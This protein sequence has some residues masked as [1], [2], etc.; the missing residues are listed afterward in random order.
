MPKQQTKKRLR[1][2][3][4]EAADGKQADQSEMN[5]AMMSKMTTFLPIMM[6][7]IMV[8]LPGAL[9]LYYT[10]SNLVAVIQQRSILQKDSEEMIAIADAAPIAQ[11]KK[12]T[13]KAR[14]K[15]AQEAN[16]I[17]ITAKDTASKKVNKKE[18]V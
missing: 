14:E 18:K 5:A 16:I 8:N 12:A 9:V 10:V 11:N 7:F 6:L 2:I 13:A 4:G 17:R 15:Q 1:D 3:M